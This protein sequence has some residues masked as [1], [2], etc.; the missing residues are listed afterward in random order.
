MPIS[1]L[2]TP[3]QP[4]W[5]SRPVELNT[6]SVSDDQVEIVS[7][8]AASTILP[9]EV[10][11]VQASLSNAS[12]Q[13]LRAAGT[14]YPTWVTDRYLQIP[15]SITPRTLAL[16]QQITVGLDNPYD[17]VNAITNYL[18]TNIVYVDRLP[19]P[20]E[21]QEQIDWML[22]DIQKGFCNYYA[23]AE[24]VLLRALG[25]PAR[26]AVGYSQGEYQSQPAALGGNLEESPGESAAIADIEAVYNVLA[27]NAHSWPEVY[28]PGLGWIPFEPTVNQVVLERPPEEDLEDSLI[29][30]PPDPFGS[31]DPLLPDVGPLPEDD[32]D[33][34][35]D[36]NPD[37]DQDWLLVQNLT[38]LIFVLGLVLLTWQ[39]LRRFRDFPPLPVFVEVRMSRMGIQPP[40]ILRR[41][42]RWANLSS[43]ERSYQEI[44]RALA[45]LGGRPI[46]AATPT[47][48]AAFL[49]HQLPESAGAV[50]VLL[51]EYQA[52]IYG[53]QLP[54]V[55]LARSLARQ[56]KV[57]S[58]TARIRRLFGNHS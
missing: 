57:Q 51:E 4:E 44:N 28:F 30:S 32:N 48:R 50:Q 7:V 9:G 33:I 31:E 21:D 27:K 55:K 58:Y 15:D 25:I 13:S 3:S 14:E 17:Q 37:A 42:A 19:K 6:I 8:N 36:F 20:P 1:T 22:F 34:P 23:T 40:L 46:Q 41:W 18:R 26:L 47:E 43:L 5:V 56:I 54:K 16:A 45:R 24:V 39:V 12:T 10:Y 11:E 49:A 52:A 53:A 38:I 29:D 2:Y 35:E